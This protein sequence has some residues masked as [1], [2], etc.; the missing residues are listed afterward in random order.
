MEYSDETRRYRARVSRVGIMA[1]VVYALLHGALQILTV[2]GSHFRLIVLTSGQYN[3]IPELAVVA[4]GV[5]ALLICGILSVALREKPAVVEAG[6]I[7]GGTAV[8]LAAPVGYMRSQLL[9]I[10]GHLTQMD[11]LISFAVLAVVFVGYA[12]GMMPRRAE[13][14]STPRRGYRRV[15]RNTAIVSGIMLGAVLWLL[16]L[17]RKSYGSMLHVLSVEQQLDYLLWNPLSA[18]L[19]VA[20]AVILG[21]LVV[22]LAALW[23]EAPKKRLIGKGSA[24]VM[25]AALAVGVLD[26][27]LLVLWQIRMTQNVYGEFYVAARMQWWQRTTSALASLLGLWALCRLLPVLRQ[28]KTALLGARCLLGITVLDQLLSWGMGVMQLV[29]RS[30]S[31]GMDIDA[32]AKWVKAETWGHLIT[33][34]LAVAALCILTVELTRRLQVGKGFWTVPVLTAL[35]VVLPLLLDIV[36]ELILRGTDMKI[37]NMVRTVLFSAIPA[38]VTLI[39]S[40]VGILA[41]TRTPAEEVSPPADGTAEGAEPP[42]PRM[43]DYLYQL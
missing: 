43:E 32:Y 41:L 23:D 4:V 15:A 6:W 37:E 26:L 38:A 16:L 10:T 21:Y 14:D 40:L 7:I 42:K 12:Y 22:A 11:F 28:S 34:L 19:P 2:Y 5:A 13:A 36:G 29:A 24:L 27:G 30:T 17:T 1:A 20:L 3:I 31:S 25:W 33:T 39:R 18:A 8:L 9:N 35:I